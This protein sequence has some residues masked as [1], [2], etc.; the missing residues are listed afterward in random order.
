MLAHSTGHFLVVEI[1]TEAVALLAVSSL[2]TLTKMSSSVML[3]LIL[4]NPLIF[5]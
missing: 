4:A 5:D 2:P 3:A 1:P